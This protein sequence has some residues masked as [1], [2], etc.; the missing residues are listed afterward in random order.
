[1]SDKIRRFIECYVP[2]TTCN[3]RCSYC[4]VIQQ[5]RRNSHS[6]EFKYTPEHIGKA[7]S[8]ERWGGVCLFSLTAPGETLI[9]HEIV[10]IAEKILSHGHYVNITTNGTL[11]KRFDEIVLFPEA[12]LE[13]LHFSFSFH[14]LELMKVSKLSVFFKN[15]DKV[16]RAGCSF[17]VQINLCDEYIP[18]LEEIKNLC[19]EKVGAPP[20]I[21]VTRDQS[22]G[23]IC[24]RTQHTTDEYIQMGN[25]FD[26]PLF[27]FGMKNFLVKR[28]E[29]CYAGDWS[30]KLYLHTGVLRSCYDSLSTQNIFKNPNKPIRFRAIGNNCKSPY[31]VNS[32]HFMSLGVIP[33]IVTPSYAELRNR[34]DANWYTP[35]MQAFLG[36]KLSDENREYGSSRKLIANAAEYLRWLTKYNILRIGRIGRRFADFRN[37]RKRI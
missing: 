17:L 10:S 30:F 32:T 13:R 5:N 4:Y 15:V 2:V 9:A 11:S 22:A 33:E 3:L 6:S 20:Q 14:Y 27:D 8:K 23:H 21:A 34:P 37:K 35:K 24:L 26:S 28:K 12:F 1:M 18:Y 25:S 7:V 31:C 19:V 16:S 36:G 29:F